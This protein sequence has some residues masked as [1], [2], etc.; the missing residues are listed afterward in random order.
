MSFSLTLRSRN[1]HLARWFTVLFLLTFPSGAAAQLR[2]DPV[3]FLPSLSSKASRSRSISGMN[4]SR[5]PQSS[6]S[7]SSQSLTS[8]AMHS[9]SESS[10]ISGLLASQE[11]RDQRIGASCS[12]LRFFLLALG[13]RFGAM[14][15]GGR[16]IRR[17]VMAAF[18]GR[19]GRARPGHPELWDSPCKLSIRKCSIPTETEHPE[20]RFPLSSACC[21][22]NQPNGPHQ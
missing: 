19:F 13:L 6:W 2:T 3:G 16:R 14:S 11:E 22:P 21:N 1:G 5:T 8:N 4:H 20:R 9:E 17:F 18:L 12:A 15:E 7:M 10:F